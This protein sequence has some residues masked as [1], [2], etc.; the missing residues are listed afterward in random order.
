MVITCGSLGCF[1]NTRVAGHVAWLG[2]MRVVNSEHQ[3]SL[4][5]QGSHGEQLECSLCNEIE[6]IT[7]A[8][9]CLMNYI[10]AECMAR[11]TR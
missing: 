5:P 6:E 11:G 10:R 4:R 2:P 3:C 8:R 1:G 9:W 7:T